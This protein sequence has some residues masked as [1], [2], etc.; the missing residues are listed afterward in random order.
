[1]EEVVSRN[2]EATFQVKNMMMVVMIADEALISS[3][4][5]SS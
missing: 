2:E 3:C 4:C 1:M 5:P